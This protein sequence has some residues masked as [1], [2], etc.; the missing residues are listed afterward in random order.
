MNPMNPSTGLLITKGF[1]RQ[2][3]FGQH[4]NL[5]FTYFLSENKTFAYDRL[6]LL[7]AKSGSAYPGPDFTEL[8]GAQKPNVSVRAVTFGNRQSPKA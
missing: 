4:I 2:R 3:G 6:G 5:S 7:W 8:E 1:V